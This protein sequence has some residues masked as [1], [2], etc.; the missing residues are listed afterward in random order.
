MEI[1]TLFPEVYLW[2]YWLNVYL[3][4]EIFLIF[5]SSISLFFF[6]IFMA[7]S[8]TVTFKPF[9][10]LH[11]QQPIKKTK[12]QNQH[13]STNHHWTSAFLI[14]IS[15]CGPF[16]MTTAALSPICHIATAMEE[17]EI[18]HQRF[19]KKVMVLILTCRIE[20]FMKMLT[21]LQLINE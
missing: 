1:C 17:D 20:M 21:Q 15:A 6:Q 19:Y 8:F 18:I 16:A 5:S 4:S 12:K 13:V 9:L 3:L 14:S 7:F 10:L 11:A 2:K